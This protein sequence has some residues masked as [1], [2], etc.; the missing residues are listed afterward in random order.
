MTGLVTTMTVKILRLS[1]AGFTGDTVHGKGTL[2]LDNVVMVYPEIPDVA[3]EFADCLQLG[4]TFEVME[5]LAGQQITLSERMV[6]E[7][8][9]M[10]MFQRD[11]ASTARRE[12]EHALGKIGCMRTANEGRIGIELPP[13]NTAMVEIHSELA[14]VRNDAK[15][16]VTKTKHLKKKE[17]Y[18]QNQLA[19][20]QK[21]IMDLEQQLQAPSVESHP[22]EATPL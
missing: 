13:L 5:F 19:E 4:T 7:L 3:H 15:D 18:A 6:E 9:K 1:E 20:A 2:I 16:M 12:D 22:I 14:T 17:K 10:Q 21:R 11:L 8:A